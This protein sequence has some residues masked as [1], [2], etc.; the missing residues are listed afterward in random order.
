MSARALTIAGSDPTGGAGIQQDL[1]TFAASG[2]WGLSA[3]AAVT[4]QDTH[5]VS[6]W[7]AVKPSLVR[8]QIDGVLNDIGCD[9][10]K[11][12]MLGTAENV[13]AVA[14]AV[15][16]HSIQALVVDPVLAAGGGSSLA[17]EGFLEALRELLLPRATLITPNVLEAAALARLAVETLDEQKEVAVAL[18]ALG[19]DAVLVTGGHIEGPRVT[20]VLFAEG[21]LHELRSD[22]LDTG[23]VHGTGCALSAAIT[24]CIAKGSGVEEAVRTA[25]V[26]VVDAIARAKR[27]GK[28]AGLLEIRA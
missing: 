9:A 25:R 3:I 18:A 21:E 2:V 23:A 5:G 14:K 26:A 1:K 22:R 28:G 15:A 20:D 4:V 6:T 17:G 11:T 16:D 8:A 13:E 7:E 12:G 24:A 19:P 10:A 27:L